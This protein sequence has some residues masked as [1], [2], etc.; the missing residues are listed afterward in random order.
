MHLNNFFAFA[1]V[2][3]LQYQE[4]ILLE[5][6]AHTELIEYLESKGINKFLFPN[7]LSEKVGSD[8][9]QDFDFI[10]EDL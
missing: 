7:W 5:K 6:V 9:C 3:F 1:P 8:V 4:S 2:A 10:C